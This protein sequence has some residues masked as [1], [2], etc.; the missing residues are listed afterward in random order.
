[1]LEQLI[2]WSASQSYPIIIVLSDLPNYADVVSLTD[3]AAF[4]I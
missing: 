1:M 3:Y 4:N 2:S